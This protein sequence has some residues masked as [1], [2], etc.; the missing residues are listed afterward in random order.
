MRYF[1]ELAYNGTRFQ[2]YQIQPNGITVQEKLEKGLSTLLKTPTSIVGCGRTD[3]GVHAAQYFAHFDANSPVSDRFVYALNALVGYDIA[4]YD[5]HQVGDEAHARFDAQSRSYKYYISTRPNPFS[6][7]VAYHHPRSEYLDR[8]K[9]QE[10]AQLLL[11]YKEFA[12]F[13]KT[14]T[15]VKT[16]F[17]TL[18]RSEWI[19]DRE[20][21]QLIYHVSANRFLRGMIRLIVGM[22]LN[23]GRGKLELDTVRKALDEQ[24]A[25]QNAWSV[26]PQG[27]FLMDIKYPYI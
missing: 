23:V 8:N 2:G 15:D 20:K 22:C 17:C 13:C 6:R 4:I 7:E 27:L 16:M 19:E 10:A 5:I 21:H 12:T 14:N 9:M 3:T 24:T 26:P 25:L 1:L 11:E 18:T